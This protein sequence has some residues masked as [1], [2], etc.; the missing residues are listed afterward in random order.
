MMLPPEAPLPRIDRL[1]H[2]ARIVA[3]N[4]RASDNLTESVTDAESALP[5]DAVP[6]QPDAVLG[7]I[8]VSLTPL[9]GV[10]EG[11]WALARETFLRHAGPA[12]TKI[13]R[14]QWDLD[15]DQIIVMEAVV[16]ADGSRPSFTLCKG[17]VDPMDPFMGN[18]GGEVAAAEANGLAG[19]AD[20]VG[21]IQ[22]GGGSAARFI[23]TGT[24]INDDPALVLTNYHVLAQA[25]SDFGVAFRQEGNHLLIEGELEIDFDG[26]YCSLGTR[27]FRI[28]EAWLPAG[29]GQTF[30]GL[31]ATVARIEPLD[32]G[33][34]LPRAVS[35]LSLDP[36]YANGAQPALATVGFPARPR[37]QDGRDVN[38]NFVIATLFGNRFG[39]KRLAP[40]RFTQPLG[41]Y[42]ADASTK[43][44]IGHDA[45]TFGGASGSLIVSWLDVGMPA[46]ALHFGGETKKAN[47]ALA[48]AVVHDALRTIGLRYG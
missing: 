17:K 36:I 6:Q 3:A 29:Y 44:V 16:I 37:L 28:V 2:L 34:T 23:G 13:S 11:E 8:N 4:E 12:L 45:T 18:W 5:E 20:G 27:R 38:W 46:F 33:A 15:V 48:F 24:L 14:N 32:A 25:K 1:R 9:P 7:R 21:R 26:E 10:D 47:Y 31:D 30:A 41:S 19:L 42:P 40:G 35:P 22:P 39:V 43:R